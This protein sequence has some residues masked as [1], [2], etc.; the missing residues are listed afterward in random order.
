MYALHISKP[1]I[2]IVSIGFSRSWAWVRLGV[3]LA[4]VFV[5]YGYVRILKAIKTG[6]EP[7]VE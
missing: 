3:S 1:S 5:F 7:R 2:R 4:W 6:Q